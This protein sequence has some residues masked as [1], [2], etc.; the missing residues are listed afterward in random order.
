MQKITV[1]FLLPV[2]FL[3]LFTAVLYSCKKDKQPSGEKIIT[4]FYFKVADNSGVI[5]TD[6]IGRISNDSIYVRVPVNTAVS[7]LV[8]SVIPNWYFIDPDFSVSVSTS[9]TIHGGTAFVGTN[10]ALYALNIIDGAKKWRYSN[11]VLNYFSS[12]VVANDLLYTTS[13]DKKLYAF[14]IN[15]G[16]VTWSTANPTNNPVAA[17]A[18]VFSGGLNNTL[19]MLDARKGNI[20][21]SSRQRVLS[22]QTPAL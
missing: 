11:V 18:D 21:G 16:M 6:I 2:Y 5:T 12:P 22:L 10:R 4:Y 8:P 20:N 9:P 7:A 3:F 1:R 17:N 14:D 13:S 19:Y 15:T